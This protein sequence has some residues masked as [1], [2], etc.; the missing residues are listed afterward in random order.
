[1]FIDVLW[2]MDGHVEERENF[3]EVAFSTGTRIGLS[4]EGTSTTGVETGPPP[5]ASVL[6]STF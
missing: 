1:M 6:T 2:Y 5:A 3:L 4:S